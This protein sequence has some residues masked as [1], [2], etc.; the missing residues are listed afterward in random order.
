MATRTYV[1]TKGDTWEWEE[2]AES[3]KALEIYWHI[4]ESNRKNNEEV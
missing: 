4:V 3:V 1:S 2:T